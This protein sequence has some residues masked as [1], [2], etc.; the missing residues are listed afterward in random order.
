MLWLELLHQAD[1]QREAKPYVS[2]KLSQN[3]QI[4]PLSVALPRIWFDKVDSV[5]TTRPF[6]YMKTICS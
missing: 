1:F 5:K 4:Q 3:Y 6:F 2:D